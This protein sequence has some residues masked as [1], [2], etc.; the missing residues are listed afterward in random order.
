[1]SD[2]EVVD[3]CN[4]AKANSPKIKPKGQEDVLYFVN[5]CFQDDVWPLL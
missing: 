3:T 5:L 1:M 4:S 2:R